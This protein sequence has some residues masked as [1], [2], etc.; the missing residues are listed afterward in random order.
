MT[1]VFVYLKIVFVL[2]PRDICVKSHTYLNNMKH[3]LNYS[4]SVLLLILLGFGGVLSS[5]S[6]S[7]SKGEDPHIT[8][9]REV[10]DFQSV[11]GSQNITIS[12]N[13]EG[14]RATS[15]KSW[16]KVLVQGKTIRITLEE[17]EEL[18]VREA[19]ITVT[20]GNITKTITVRQLGSEPTILVDKPIVTI[21]ASGGKLDFIITAN[22][23]FDVK[24][25]DWVQSPDGTRAIQTVDY[26]KSYVVAA[27]AE[28]NSRTASIEITQT[29]ASVTTGRTPKTV[30]VSVTQLGL[31]AGTT[32]LPAN[33]KDIKVRVANGSASSHQANGGEFRYSFDGDFSTIYHSNWNN[34][35]TDYFPITLQYDFASVEDIDY[36]IYYPRQS[37]SNGHIK[38]VEISYSPDGSTWVSLGTKNWGGTA[39]A[40]T[41]VFDKTL[42]AKSFKFVV[43]SGQGDGQGFVSVSEMEFYKYN[44]DKFQPS[45]LFK[46]DLCSE[47]KDN[48]TEQEILACTD[49]FF[50]DIAYRM[51]HKKYNR[52]F[53]VAEFK[54]WTEPWKQVEIHSYKANPYSLLDN[55]T[56]IYAEENSELVVIVGDTHGHSDLALWLINFDQPGG[57]GFNNR[58]L[59]SLQKGVNQIKVPQK[60]LLYVA[61]YKN[62]KS[63]ADAAQ[64]I[65]IHFA[66]GIVNGYYDSKKREHKGRWLELRNKAGKYFDLVGEF[67][68]MTF[69]TENFKRVTP[70]G[71][72]LIAV[73]DSIVKH[74]MLLHGLY[75]YNRVRTNRMFM[76]VMYH[77]FMY[78]T[79]Y[80]TGYNVSTADG[81][82]NAEEVVKG[83]N[84]WGPAHEIGHMNQT[85]PGVLWT[86]LTE[87]TVNIPSAYIQTTLYKQGCRVQVEEMNANQSHS[88]YTKAFNSII[89]PQVPHAYNSP[90]VFC[91]LIPFWQLELYFGKVLGRTPMSEDGLGG[92]YPEV[93]EYCRTNASPAT[94]GEVQL[95]FAFIASKIANLDLTDFF[96]AWGF[97]RPVD[98]TIDDYGSAKFA[99]TQE[100]IDRV[101]QRIKALNLNKPEAKIQYISDHSVDAYRSKAAIQMG[102]AQIA[103]GKDIT[104]SG[105]RN[106]VAWEVRN[107]ADELTY[108]SDGGI[109]DNPASWVLALPSG[110][111]T[112]G[113]KLYAVDWKGSK[114][115][116][117]V[118]Q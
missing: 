31:N 14:L 39:T 16:C 69:P 95:E 18:D 101:K 59:L 52:E 92:F 23:P 77:Q 100:Q 53:R 110:K 44:P 27:Y 35:G 11:A 38:E 15:N 61:Y 73:Y 89:V 99:V 36:L 10:V 68:H 3:Y 2:L 97:F 37:G 86:G 13:I 28:E 67:A 51:F 5:C 106:V 83:G 102:T 41:V 47:L 72:K 85:R 9:N 90:D 96:E 76:H 84:M 117:S 7:D 60:G 115:L 98:K 54:A 26:P 34:R 25:P 17:S 81:L 19:T 91:Q 1:E 78:A 33:S 4:L 111:W 63:E 87:C 30:L 75:K 20:G 62:T 93:Y 109:K 55:P 94:M 103:S 40:K 43:H 82:L 79:Y 74:E 21:P 66:N 107:A 48:I 57:D 64:P 45:T 58:R 42:K 49:P 32:A 80:H 113:S 8:I 46:D 22:V 105:F 6:G 112:E 118:T 12:T 24:L 108:L 114:T 104:L 65:K 70:D 50:R 71:D 29:A 116:V 88:R 56:G